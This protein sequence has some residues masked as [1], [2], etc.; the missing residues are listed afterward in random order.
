MSSLIDA[1]RKL[2]DQ[3][4]TWRRDLHRIPEVGLEL[5]KTARYVAEVLR[6]LGLE[7]REGVGGHGVVAVLRG[8]KGPGRTFA[9]RADMDALPV[10]EETGLPFASQHPGRMHACAHD[11]HMAM[12]L[13]AAQV[14]SENRHRLPGCVKFI[15]QPAEEGPG[16]AKP[17]I[18]DRCLEEPRVDAIIGLHLGNIWDLPSGTV[19]V[20]AGPMMAATDRFEITVRGKGG[21]GAMP[22]NTQD[23]LCIAAQLVGALQTV[24]SRN[25][26]PLA[27]A[28]LT[29]GRFH[30]GTAF[31]IIAE[32]AHLEGTVRCLSEEIRQQIPQHM[33]RIIRGI[34]QA[35]GAQYEFSYH[36]GYPV[37][38]NDPDFTAF[39]AQVARE[40]V[41]SER[42]RELDVP[43]MGGEDMA[44][45]LQQVPGT[46]FFLASGTEEKGT[47]YPHHNPRF[48]FDEEVMWIGTA[49]FVETA[50]RWLSGAVRSG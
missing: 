43:T 23:A 6:N 1:A 20:K 3:L 36:W 16:G 10:Q 9:I 11:G 25:L 39:F 21:H 18:D 41:G 8:R 15:F 12:A 33:E 19:G 32:T 35:G 17:M 27:P 14:L 38:V 31:N 49:L 37:L 47:K 30:A 50:M 2:Q 40:V 4:V 5:P 24:V 28:V 22:H 13:G 48:D 7:V 45:Y 46:F 34:T 29:V 44:Y 42:V 26:S